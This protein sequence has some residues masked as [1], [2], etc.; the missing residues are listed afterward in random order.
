M[1]Q[2]PDDLVTGERQ[3]HEYKQSLG[4][5]KAILHQ[6]AFT[7]AKQPFKHQSALTI[8]NPIL[9]GGNLVYIFDGLLHQDHLEYDFQSTK[10]SR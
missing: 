9:L 6:L 7:I 2:Q 8:T 5:G 4:G 3:R 1:P 10:T